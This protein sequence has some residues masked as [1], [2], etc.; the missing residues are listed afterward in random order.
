MSN[1][2][3]SNVRAFEAVALSLEFGPCMSDSV[4]VSPGIESYLLLAIE[5]RVNPKM[6]FRFKKDQFYGA[7]TI[8]SR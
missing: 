1:F 8:P 3:L 5:F 7:I 6:K 2:C 4:V